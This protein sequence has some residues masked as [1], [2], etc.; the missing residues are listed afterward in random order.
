MAWTPYASARIAAPYGRPGCVSDPRP[1]FPIQLINPNLL[2]AIVPLGTVGSGGE[3][4]NR[5]QMQIKTA[6]GTESPL[7]VPADGRVI[8][9]RHINDPRLNE[10]W[11]F[12][13]EVS[14]EV[15]LAVD[16]VSD[17]SPTFR[18]FAPS[19]PIDFNTS[20]NAEFSTVAGNPA[21]HAGESLGATAGGYSATASPPLSWSAFDYYVLN[22]L[23]VNPFSNLGR[24]F[25]SNELHNMLTADCALDYHAAADKAA[26]YAKLGCFLPTMAHPHGCRN[27]SRDVAGSLVGTWFLAPNQ[28]GAL[29]KQFA[30][31]TENIGNVPP[32]G[33]QLEVNATFAPADEYILRYSDPSIP[34]FDPAGVEYPAPAQH[35]FDTFQSSANDGSSK[36][37]WFN[38]SAPDTVQVKRGTGDSCPTGDF[39]RDPT[40]AVT[41]IR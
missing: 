39:L 30:I 21:V 38:L 7:T 37:V 40:P 3:T 35:C 8:S 20:S 22:A 2:L 13:I 12:G 11:G 26:Y 31:A 23:R 29:P 5:H 24:Y 32:Q 10:Y 25:S 18:A 36:W 9:A 28:T 27:T 33:D 41:Y 15:T 19:A 1:V 16:H 6:G 34:V 4:K 17:P 14:C